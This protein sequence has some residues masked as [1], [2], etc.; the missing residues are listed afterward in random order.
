MIDFSQNLRRRF[1]DEVYKAMKTNDKI[2]VVAGDLGY[3]MW[4]Q[5]RQDFPKRFYNVGA[6]EQSLIGIGVGLALEGKIPIV[7]S[8]TSFLLYRPFETIRNYI[9]HE[10]IPVILVGA[11]RDKDYNHDG[12]SHWSEEDREVM[13]I[14]NNINS[15]WPE[16]ADEVSQITPKIINS[17]Q[18]WYINLKR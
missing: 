15:V 13:K 17:H 3:K 10:K 2:I 16:S 4:D 18:P 9:N 1:A 14:F 8:I 12:F 11:G 5:I 6:A 7:F